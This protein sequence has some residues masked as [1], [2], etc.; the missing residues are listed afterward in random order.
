MDTDLSDTSAI[1]LRGASTVGT[2]HSCIF[3]LNKTTVYGASLRVLEGAILNMFA[4]RFEDNQAGRGGAAVEGGFEDD[5]SFRG[6]LRFEDCIFERNHADDFSPAVDVSRLEELV[7]VRCEF[8]DNTSGA[9]GGAAY[10]YECDGVLIQDCIF[11]NNRAEDSGGALVLELDDQFEAVIE[12]CQFVGNHANGQGGALTL[13]D[14]QHLVISDTIF[15]QNTAGEEGGAIHI[16]SDNG[17]STID[18]SGVIC[19]NNRSDGSGGC[20]LVEAGNTVNVLSSATRKTSFDGNTALNGSDHVFL[21]GLR[22]NLPAS[23]LDCSGA[24]STTTTPLFTN[25]TP[26]IRSSPSTEFNNTD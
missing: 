16:D 24:T 10:L 17:D 22:T 4:C 20:L 21:E 6:K 2:F 26:G 23:V 8:V 13:E 3:R 18:L 1:L 9:Y 14:N 11:R 12:G 25:P 19:T 15:D 5:D 7:L